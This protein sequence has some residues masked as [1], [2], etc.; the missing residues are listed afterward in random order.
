MFEG[1]FRPQ[2]FFCGNEERAVTRRIELSGI[3][4]RA[5]NPDVSNCEKIEEGR[6][7]RAEEIHRF[8][9]LASQQG[10]GEISPAQTAV[11]C[12][13][14]DSLCTGRHVSEQINGEVV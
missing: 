4:R 3:I 13:Q 5:Q 2:L 10:S 6:A 7:L 1:G 12:R 14:R 9:R 11:P 8:L